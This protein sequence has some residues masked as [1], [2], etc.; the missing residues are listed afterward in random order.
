LTADAG[1]LWS[2]VVVEESVVDGDVD[3]GDWLCSAAK[4]LC[5]NDVTASVALL[6][7]LDAAVDDASVV[8]LPA[9]EDV[10]LPD[11]SSEMPRLAN[12]FWIAVTKR[13]APLACWVLPDALSPVDVEVPVD[14]KTPNRFG[15]VRLDTLPIEERDMMVL[16]HRWGRDAARIAR[17]ASAPF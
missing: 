8:A 5:R 14:G 10:V 2:L 4:R 15:V 3:P 13:L 6:V 16:S 11:V 17:P 12:A 1:A 9:V 7:S